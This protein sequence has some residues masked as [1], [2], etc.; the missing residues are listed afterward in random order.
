[1]S[2][3]KKKK[4]KF[5]SKAQTLKGLSEMLTSASILPIYIFTVKDFRKDTLL[6]IKKIHDFFKND[7]L[8]VRSSS[9]NEDASEISNAGHF[10]SVLNVNRENDTELKKA[11]E[12]VIKSYGKN[13]PDTEEI[14][15]QPQLSNIEMAGVAF[16]SNIDTLAPYYTIN[17]DESGSTDSVTNGKGKNLKTFVCFKESPV[18]CENKKLTSLI[19]SLKELENIFDFNHLDV[20]FAFTKE[21]KPYIFQVRKI[22]KSGKEDLSQIDLGY[23]LLKIH[24][25]IVKLSAPHPNLLGEH[26]VYGVMPDWNP[27]EIIGLKPKHLAASLYKEIITDSIWAYQ[28]DNYGYRNLRSH[29]L[30]LLFLGVPYIDVRVDFNSFIPK[31]LDEKI[32]KK[33]VEYYL[34]KLISSPALHDKIEF[35]I[36]HSCFYFNLPGRLSNDLGAAGFTAKEIRSI[37]KALLTITN[38]IINPETGLYKKD[39]K[40]AEK[41][42]EKYDQITSSQLSIVDKIYWLLEDC[43]R[44]GTL[45]F[46]GIARSAF[47]ATQFLRSFVELNIIS[48]EEYNLF[49]GSINTIT[50]D[51]NNDLASLYKKKI[52]KENFLK[53]YGHLRPGTYDILSSRYDENFDNYFS[54][55]TSVHSEHLNFKFSERHLSKID[56]LIKKHG[57]AITPS[58]LIDFIRISIEGREK[59]KFIFTKSL[60]KVLSLIEELAIKY[61]VKRDDLPYLD[62]KTILELYA[63]LDYRDVK[64]IFERDIEKNKRTYKYTKAV[65]LPSLISNP[66]DVYFHFLHVEE[67]NYITLKNIC[68]QVVSQEVIK[69]IDL[70]NKI[71]FIKSAD[72]GFDFLFSKNIGGLVTQ[73]GGANSHM[74]VRCAELGIP[75][76]IGAGEINFNSWINAKVLEIDCLNQLVRIIS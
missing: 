67:P 43:K 42:K 54:G 30:M 62:I 7:F 51:L 59:V 52:T 45:P 63:S 34:K 72:P 38:T 22:S 6:V 10:E 12:N 23:T 75:A 29:P 56:D 3:V 36:V 18:N 58:E 61:E 46:A 57:L 70:H 74:A 20:E 66:N 39:L 69:S 1:M 50:K 25:K 33:L 47:I 31:E 35:E 53:K 60:S 48:K 44:Y 19:T 11:I 21:K 13:C 73:F 37:E 68:S 5:S 65:K 40:Q 9:Q 17:Y 15:V 4:L 24:K 16:T 28:R 14:F 2:P 27:A 64:E 41:L 55:K 71:I 26:A 76:V 49:I 8:V 32:A